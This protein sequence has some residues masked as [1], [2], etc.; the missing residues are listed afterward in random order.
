MFEHLCND[1]VANVIAFLNF[2]A[3]IAFTKALN[4]TNRQQLSPRTAGTEILT[5]RSRSRSRSSAIVCKQA[6]SNAANHQN[7]YM[8]Q[9]FHQLWRDI[10][11]RHL[12][13]PPDYNDDCNLDY[14]QLCNQKRM[15][16]NRLM[17]QNCR[18][19]KSCFS[20]PNQCFYFRPL[21]P[22]GEGAVGIVDDDF[23]PVDFP[24]TS[25][26]LT[27]PGTGG[28][29]VLLDPFD[30]SLTVYNNIMLD[31]VPKEMPAI[32]TGLLE[33]VLSKRD[34]V[35]NMRPRQSKQESAA[36]GLKARKSNEILFSVEDYFQLDLSEYLAQNQGRFPHRRMNGLAEDDD[37]V[38]DWIGIDT[39][40][41]IDSQQNMIGTMICA[42]RELL[43]DNT[44]AVDGRGNE[45]LTC[46]ELLAW[47][48][49]RDDGKYGECR[50][51]CRMDG[52]PFYMEV[53]AM[54]ERVYACFAPEQHGDDNVLQDEDDEFINDDVAG[55]HRSKR[56]VIF[57]LMKDDGGSGTDRK[58]FPQVQETFVCNRPISSF[59]IEPTGNH[60][61]IGT[62]NGTVEIWNVG[63]STHKPSLRERIDI[64]A[65][66]EEVTVTPAVDG[67]AETAS[68]QMES[69]SSSDDMHSMEEDSVDD[70]S[71]ILSDDDD[72][73]NGGIR[74][75]PFAERRMAYASAL[76]HLNESTQSEEDTDDDDDGDESV[77]TLGD[78]PMEEDEINNVSSLSQCK[79]HRMINQIVLPRHLPIEK[80]G[81]ITLQHHRSEGTTLML[82]FLHSDDAEE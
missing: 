22:E 23:P 18:R 33:S 47:K 78:V 3:A 6:K 51:K 41:M 77:S 24:C 53:C 4:L 7:E 19:I 61:I 25:Y 14:V 46:T 55:I 31:V 63:K 59:V 66:I 35:Q 38:V 82:W 44:G 29:Y 36:A 62:D 10:Y 72:A 45:Y 68:A 43:V 54:N 27:S 8:Q 40:T 9:C 17:N 79:P 50:Y 52:S 60:L 37:V 81:F 13:S 57:P 1:T 30:G 39:H 11:T 2:N 67:K 73:I 74:M 28:E 48:K 80:A 42:A 20:I 12:F 15:L 65:Q 21:Q 56:I 5:S 71:C 64:T 26:L 76:D 32:E 49:T 70:N 16:L 69:V 34:S 75:L 58:F